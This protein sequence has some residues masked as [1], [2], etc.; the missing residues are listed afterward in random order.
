MAFS[1][2]RES[3]SRNS[4]SVISSEGTLAPAERQRVEQLVAHCVGHLPGREPGA[5]AAGDAP[6]ELS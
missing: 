6:P 3:F 1:M 2:A 4:A 5:G